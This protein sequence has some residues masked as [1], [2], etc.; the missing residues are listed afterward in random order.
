MIEI[1]SAHY[2][3]NETHT[4]KEGGPGIVVDLNQTKASMKEDVLCLKDFVPGNV[5]CISRLVHVS[6]FM[7]P[8]TQT[9]DYQISQHQSSWLGLARALPPSVPSFGSDSFHSR[10]MVVCWG[11]RYCT[12]GAG[13]DI[14]ITCMEASWRTGPVLR[15]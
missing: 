2:F 12:L 4:H 5:V 1:V 10:R 13:A 8:R 7:C 6:Q 3:M 15:Q 14:K 9:F 11:S